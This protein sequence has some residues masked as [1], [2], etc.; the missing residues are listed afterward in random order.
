M[1]DMM[2]TASTMMTEEEKTEL[3]KA[4]NPDNSTQHLDSTPHQSTSRPASPTGANPSLSD[5]QASN[6]SPSLREKEAARKRGK[7][8]LEE[9]EKAREQERERR[10]VR[11][12]QELERRKIMEKRV[13]EL[14]IK[15]IERL[16]PFV[17]AKHPGDKDDPETITFENKI[18][19]EAEDLKLES[20]GVEVRLVL[21]TIPP[22]FS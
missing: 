17:E 16:R 22:S 21:S 20:F 2:N 1:K 5:T 12:Q 10:K 9:K 13:S 7:Q 19:K 14:T 18:R 3:E 6:S 8:T 4:L 15:M 11:D